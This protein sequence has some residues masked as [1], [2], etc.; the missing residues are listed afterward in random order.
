MAVVSVNLFFFKNEVYIFRRIEYLNVWGIVCE[1]IH[2][3]LFEA[4]IA[5]AEIGFA[6]SKW[7][8]LLGRRIVGFRTAAFGY[9]ADDI[10]FIS[11]N[12]FGE[13]TLRLDGDGNNRLLVILFWLSCIARCQADDYQEKSEDMSHIYC[14]FLDGYFFSGGQSFRALSISRFPP[15]GPGRRS[16]VKPAACNIRRT[17]PFAQ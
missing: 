17:I 7:N 4:N 12:G 13:I 10:E 9:D 14:F 8:E 2:P 5:D 6:V 16:T 11:G 15:G 3:D 1:T